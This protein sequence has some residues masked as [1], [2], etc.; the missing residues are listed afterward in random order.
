[1]K[2][3][4]LDN[5]EQLRICIFPPKF[6]PHKKSGRYI[7]IHRGSRQIETEEKF[8]VIKSYYVKK[9]FSAFIMTHNLGQ[10]IS[11]CLTLNKNYFLRSTK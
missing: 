7:N 9:N 1:M 2:K 4:L 10:N 6:F 5:I 3:L 11:H 8:C